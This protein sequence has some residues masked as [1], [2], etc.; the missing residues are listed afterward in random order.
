MAETTLKK[1][2]MEVIAISVLVAAALF[3]GLARF[4]KKPADDEVFSKKRFN[5]EWEK[6][7]KLEKEIPAVEKEIVFSVVRARTPF[8]GPFDTIKQ[9]EVKDEEI[10]LPVME[11]QG[12]IW[13]SIRPQ[14]VIDN[15]VYM[16]G[17]VIKI[18]NELEEG[19]DNVRISD[20]TEKGVHLE[21]KRTEFIVKPKITYNNIGGQ[22]ENI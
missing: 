22:N 20:I 12:V 11:F 13:N 8:E 21:Y 17:D 3:I 18:K 19:F 16:I 15:K 10:A 4:K 5:Q 1:Q 14:A 6:V 7:E 2:Q 9:I